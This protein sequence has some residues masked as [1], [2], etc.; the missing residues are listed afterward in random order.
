VISFDIAGAGRIAYPA[1]AETD[2][3]SL[4][5]DHCFVGA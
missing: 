5:T 2:H 3:Y 4:N 1:D